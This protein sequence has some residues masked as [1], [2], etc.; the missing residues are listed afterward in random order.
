MNTKGSSIV[1]FLYFLTLFTFTD[2]NTCQENILEGNS[3]TIPLST[4][5]LKDDD[6]FSIKRDNFVV[7]RRRTKGQRGPGTLEQD[8]SLILPELKLTDAGTY[9]R[10]VFDGKGNPI[11]SPWS[12]N[13]CVYAKVPTP[14]VN[15]TCQNEKVYFSCDVNYTKSLTYS[16]QRNKKKLEKELN[17]KYN[18]STNYEKDGQSK[19]ACTASNPAHNKTSDELKIECLSQ[20]TLFGFDF[21]IMVSIL[22]GGGTL[23]LILFIVLVTAS[24]RACKRKRKHQEDEEE[25]RLNYVNTG[26]PPGQ[27]KSKQTARGQPAPP[28]PYD[29]VSAHEV[30][31]AEP[32]PKTQ[33]R[34]RPPPPPIDD[35]EE[36]PPP[37][38]QPRKKQREKKLEKPV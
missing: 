16:W 24:C 38:P 25:F 27:Q 30:P 7:V 34:A 4:N 17:K 19:F 23:V 2:C 37:L 12:L 3:L 28:E 5:P 21:W 20:N 29:D 31:Q 1:L 13:V 26:P 36:H 35:E 32:R 14:T 10:E 11:G 15:I 22:A 6:R 8:K 33:Q 18:F 9:T